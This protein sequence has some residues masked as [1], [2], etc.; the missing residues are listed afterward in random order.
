MTAVY[1][2]SM[3]Q[4]YGKAKFVNGQ[5]VGED[6]VNSPQGEN[7]AEDGANPMMGVLIPP[8]QD[9]GNPGQQMQPMAQ[10]MQPAQPTEQQPGITYPEN[11]QLLRRRQQNGIPI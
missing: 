9:A 4:V 7:R 1:P 11:S 5:F 10:P 3:N 8:G 2:Y 6:Y